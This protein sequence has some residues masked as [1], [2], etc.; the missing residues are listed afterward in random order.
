MK[1]SATFALE[2]Q[3]R[4]SGSDVGGISTRGRRRSA[5]V[6][7]L[8]ESEATERVGASPALASEHLA[9]LENRRLGGALSW[10]SSPWLVSARS[11]WPAQGLMV[12]E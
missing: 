12:T 8:T 11:L 1:V 7:V 5:F 4:Y 3:S 9:L 2:R 10:G 6:T